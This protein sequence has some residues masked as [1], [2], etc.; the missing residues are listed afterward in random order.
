[1]P[2]TLS[3]E[4]GALEEHALGLAEVGQGDVH[5]KGV[6]CSYKSQEGQIGPEQ[7]IKLVKLVGFAMCGTQ[8]QGPYL[9]HLLPHYSCFTERKTDI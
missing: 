4:Q 9:V 1:M 3:N 5:Q 2:G 6:S 7:W 8:C